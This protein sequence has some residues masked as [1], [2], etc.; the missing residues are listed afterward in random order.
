MARFKFCR[1]HP[2]ERLI[3]DFYCAEAQL[4]IEVDGDS[5]AEQVDYD[6]ARAACLNA[7]SYTVIRFTNRE[8]F[9]QFEAML[10]V[11]AAEC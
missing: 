10:Q 2:S 8:V 11:I 4:C 6:Q 1:Q 9:T 5:H 3:I 7:L